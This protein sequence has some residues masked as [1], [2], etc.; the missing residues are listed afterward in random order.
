MVIAVASTLIF[1]GRATRIDSGTSVG[2]TELADG[3]FGGIKIQYWHHIA[4][5]T[6][7]SNIF[8][9]VIALVSAIVAIKNP[10]KPFS[11]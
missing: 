10:K 5:F 7:L 9:G 4:S 1:G 3:T 11:S 6:I 8:L 2:A